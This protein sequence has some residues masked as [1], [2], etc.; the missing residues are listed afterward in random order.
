MAGFSVGDTVVH[1]K[2]GQG[3]VVHADGNKLDRP[4]QTAGEKKS[5]PPSSSTLEIH[6]PA[7][8]KQVLKR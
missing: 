6:E 3:R 1:A 2:F 4:L 5:S 7:S 8:G